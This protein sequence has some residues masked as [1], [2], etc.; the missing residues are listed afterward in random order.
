VRAAVLYELG[1][2]PVF[3]D[4]KEPQPDDGHEIIEV[5]LA[6]LNPV[7]LYIA[8]GL[9]G[10]LELP[11]VMGLEGI[12]RREDGS[13]VYFEGPPAPFGAMAQFAPVDPAKLFPV[14][15]GLDPGVAVALGI[16]GLS[17]WL[18]L[19][20]RAHLEQGESVLVLGASGVVGQIG[21]QVARLLGA[22]RVVAAARHRPTLEKLLERGADEIVVL[23]GDVAAALKAATGNGG[24]DV[25]LDTIY[26]PSLEAAL[27]AAAQFARVVTVGASSGQSA[28]IPIRD[29]F[30][31]RLSGH[32]N[33]FAP[34]EH[35]REAYERM[36]AHALAGEIVIDV[37]QLPLSEVKA[38][39]ALQAAGPHA[40]L[41]LIP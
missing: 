30:G 24:Y 7:D 19:T 37:K 22:G 15:D 16:A 21:V 33:R 32:S 17:A 9:Y 4:F 20:K 27:Q 12:A 5:L 28:E 25:V 1:T 40:K 36:A 10:E 31:R 29:L 8:A 26:G 35:R 38:A 14:P 3:A 39:W 13:R 41:T 34:L 2:I 6:G 11:C 18:P 23:E